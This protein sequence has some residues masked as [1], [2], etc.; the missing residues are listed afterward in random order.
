MK[1]FA[2]QALTTIQAVWSVF[3]WKDAID[4]AIVSLF[5]Y[6]VI[7]LFKRTRSFF[8][9]DGIVLLF[10]A[11]LGAKFFNFYL[12][13]LFLQYFFGFFILIMAVIFREELKSFLESISIWGKLKKSSW[14]EGT[15][16][17][18]IIDTIEK[19]LNYL[20]LN[21][22]GALIVFPGNQP[23]ERLLQGGVVLNGMLS[24]PLLLS[25]FDTS[26]PGHD[27]AVFIEKGYIKKF[28][29]HL[30]L[31]EKY[32]K[33]RNV[34][35]RHRA[36]VGISEKSDSI[37]LVVS[38]ER[39]TISVAR[40]GYLY[41]VKN[42]KE[43]AEMLKKFFNEQSIFKSVRAWYKPFITNLPSKL[44]A[45]LAGGFLWFSFVFQLGQVT[46]EFQVPIEFR[47]LG[48]DIQVTSVI[49][50]EVSVTVSGKS[51][52]FE[53]LDPKNI[54]V[55]VD[56][57]SFEVGSSRVKIEEKMIQIPSSLSIIDFSPGTVKFKVEEKLPPKESTPFLPETEKKEEK[58]Q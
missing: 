12:T 32:E 18:K 47:Y 40:F 57:S 16:E 50:S 39:G 7:A 5:I 45:I 2:L 55:I 56:A 51:N 4:I 20:S 30:P 31:A 19:T 49:P 43:A 25:I 54:K 23:L 21:K 15:D 38:E 17:S 44:L 48:N 26:S 53:L 1:V 36:A 46:T 52:N 9:I 8:I 11:Y 3:S 28:G 42:A 13:G 29:I 35:T 34:G 41:E 33:L 14:R 22:I 6:L 58:K 24:T 10:I 37:T 27:G